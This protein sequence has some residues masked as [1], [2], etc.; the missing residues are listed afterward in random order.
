[1]THNPS[2]LHQETQ[3]L[4]DGNAVEWDAYMGE[5]R[6][7]QRELVGPAT[8]RLLEVQ[9]GQRVLDVACGN[10]AFS[11]RLAAQGATVVACDFSPTF[12]E[13][14]RERTTEHTHRITYHVIDATDEPQ[15][16]TLGAKQYD[17]AVCTMALM[18]MTTI[19]PLF[20]ALHRLLKPGGIFVY[21]LMHPCFNND[22][23][24]V[25]EQVEDETGVHTRFGIRVFQYLTPRVRRGFGIATQPKAQ[26]Y[27]FRP[28]HVLFNTG[29]QA[30]F[31][32]DGLE[33]PAFQQPAEPRRTLGWSS[34]TELPPVLVVRL[35]NL[36]PVST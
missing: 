22:N 33:E 11:R 30:G 8:E 19:E 35:R 2:T 1:M 34:Y 3:A 18:D 23:S 6:A 14:A 36:G 21:S 25:A 16:M 4:W 5:G 17:A 7:F 27:F 13:K 32:L 10:G 20:A 31:V 24:M 15:L 29:F 26:Y 9:P 28:L 12:I